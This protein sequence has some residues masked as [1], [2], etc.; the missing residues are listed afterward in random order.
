MKKK[1]IVRSL[2]GV[3]IGMAI[4]MVITLVISFCMRDGRFYYVP[5]ALTVDWGSEVNAALVQVIGS[6]LYG[7]ISCMSSIVWEIERWSLLKI[8]VVHFV[9]LTVPTICIAYLLYWMP[10][11]WLGIV[12][13]L[14]M[15]VVIYA[16]IWCSIYFPLK[17]KVRKIR[18]KIAENN[19]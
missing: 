19:Q 7:A 17:R 16:G 18:E 12:G 9:W 15:F 5:P 14:G 10:H 4:G 11:H 3:P 1:L 6:G 8:T 13:Y 2:M